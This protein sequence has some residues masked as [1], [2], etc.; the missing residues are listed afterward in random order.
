MLAALCSE[1]HA[2]LCARAHYPPAK[3]LRD[4]R[5]GFG[6]YFRPADL[7]RRAPD[8]EDIPFGELTHRDN[9]LCRAVCVLPQSGGL[10]NAVRP[11]VGQGVVALAQGSVR[12]SCIHEIDLR[13]MC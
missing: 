13:K 3:L 6:A 4:L 11:V 12:R 10:L 1:V 9:F 8:N 2:V 5:T 7:A